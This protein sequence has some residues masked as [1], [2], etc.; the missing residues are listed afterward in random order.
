MP[1]LYYTKYGSRKMNKAY[2]ELDAEI[3]HSNLQTTCDWVDSTN[4]VKHNVYC[5]LQTHITQSGH[6]HTVSETGVLPSLDC[7]SGTLCL[8]H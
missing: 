4:T 8:S 7:V 6:T 1:I 3:V 5:R 2:I